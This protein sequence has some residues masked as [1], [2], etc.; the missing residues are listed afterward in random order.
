MKTAIIILGPAGS[1][2][3]L[4]AKILYKNGFHGDIGHVQKFDR[5][6]SDDLKRKDKVFIRRSLPHGATGW[7]DTRSYDFKKITSFFEKNGFS[8]IKLLIINR[9]RKYT[10][11]SQL[12]HGSLIK[13][14]NEGKESIKR[15]EEKI[16][17]IISR[18]GFSFKLFNY[19]QMIRRPEITQDLILIFV[20]ANSR[21]FV[22]IYNGDKKYL[23][24]KQ[25]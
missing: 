25:K 4:L 20:G 23:I 14:E 2:T 16:F 19:E 11:K 3:R 13:N 10:I 1:G 21:N 5:F 18:T 7:K 6:N 12:S 22:K 15:A 8:S 17:K 24:I 9:T